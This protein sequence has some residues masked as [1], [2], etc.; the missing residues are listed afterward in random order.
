MALGSLP[1]TDVVDG[2]PIQFKRTHDELSFAF[3]L[4][5]LEATRADQE[6]SERLDPFLTKV[7]LVF[8]QRHSTWHAPVR[9]ASA[10]CLRCAAFRPRAEAATA[11]DE[12]G[13]QL[14]ARLFAR[15]VSAVR[16]GRAPLV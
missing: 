2:V 13:R 12:R 11:L 3:S 1:K 14:F 5:A 4:I 6:S 7:L 8:Q 15:A 9:P 16:S 10:D